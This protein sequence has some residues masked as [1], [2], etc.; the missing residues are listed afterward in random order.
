M[1]C[2]YCGGTGERHLLCSACGGTGVFHGNQCPRC[3]GEGRVLARLAIRRLDLH[4]PCPACDGV[5]EISQVRI[6]QLFRP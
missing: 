6:A 2:F 4:L 5:G 3:R 1:T